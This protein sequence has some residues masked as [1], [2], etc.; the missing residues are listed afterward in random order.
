MKARIAVLALAVSLSSV[1]A[2]LLDSNGFA[3]G[4]ASLLHQVLRALG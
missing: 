3:T 1:G 2:R 4:L